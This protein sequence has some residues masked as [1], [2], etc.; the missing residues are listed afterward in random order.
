MNDNEKYLKAIAGNTYAI[1][2]L[3]VIL[4]VVLFLSSNIEIKLL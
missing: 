1:C 3:L 2:Y 4:I